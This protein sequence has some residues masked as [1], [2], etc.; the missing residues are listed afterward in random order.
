MAVVD[1][2]EELIGVANILLDWYELFR[3][4]TPA[5]A[6]ADFSRLHSPERDRESEVSV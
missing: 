4:T 1:Q 6:P 2:S 5:K 3:Q